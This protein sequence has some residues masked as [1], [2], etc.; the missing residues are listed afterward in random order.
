[1]NASQDPL[2]SLR[3]IH[4]PEPV[5]F[6]PLAAGWWWL[7]LS[8]AVLLITMFWLYR[9]FTRPNVRK[10]A[11]TE[12]AQFTRCVN[13]EGSNQFFIDV[14]ILIR[15]IAITVFGKNQVAGLAGESWLKFLDKTS[16]STFFTTGNG[17]LLVTAP[18]L[19]NKSLSNTRLS[20]MSESLGQN[21]VD[22]NQFSREIK[23]W[24]VKNT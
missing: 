16:G 2:N 19:S 22:I 11:L 7:I 8:S 17:R 5:S 1:M 9:H 24:V 4:L 3:D 21:D 15:R 23:N 13:D 20:N 6:W 12:L 14:S 10:H 18:Y